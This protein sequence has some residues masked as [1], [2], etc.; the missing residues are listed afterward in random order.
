MSDERDLI[1]ARVSLVELVSQTVRLTRKGKNW[2]GLCP[3][4]DDKKPSFSVH[5]GTGTYR[6]WSCGAKGDLF[7]WIM[8][9]QRLD[10]RQA[11]ELLAKMAGVTLSRTGHEGPSKRS[12]YESAMRSANEFFQEQLR[13]HG[14]ALEYCLRRG[15]TEEVIR[16]WGLGF[17]PDVPEG[18]P[19]H[20]KKSGF[21]LGDCQEV[22]LV[23]GDPQRGYIG[24]FRGRLMFPIHDERGS[25]VAFGGRLLG[26][27]IPKYINSGDTP[28]YSKRR[29]LYGL[30]QAKNFVAKED[31]AT[32]VEGYLDVIACHRA[33]LKTA[34]A[35][36]GTS[37]S[38]EHA[39]LLAR[40][41]H[42]VTILYDGDAAGQKAADRACEVLGAAGL[43]VDVAL[44]PVGE[45]PDTLLRTA[46]PDAIHRSAKGGLSPLEFRLLR[47]RNT[48][49]PEQPKFWEESIAL[50]A[51]ATP[52]EAERAIQELAPLYPDLRDPVAAREAI[53]RQVLQKT[54]TNRAPESRPGARAPRPRFHKTE[55]TGPE[56]ALL[57]GIEQ[58]EL[59]GM[60]WP[61]L[62]RAELFPTSKAYELVTMLLDAFPDEPPKGAPREW[63]GQCEPEEV[64]FRLSDLW[65]NSEQIV[66]T[67][68]IKDAIERL[69]DRSESVA[70]R[71]AWQSESGALSEEALAEIR[72]RLIR[73]KTKKP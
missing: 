36:L 33:G 25:L 47:V 44:V 28:L 42:H 40:W 24:K 13:K 2:T 26:D 39:R 11:L 67:I 22:F 63:L 31:R 50:L 21:N 7:T 14:A 5:D 35:S 70:L 32:L 52:L 10:F 38:E 16:D 57:L 51:D 72:D 12:Q 23:E 64:R 27:G 53:K 18:L 65:V 30:D 19:N 6:C 55:M 15:L 4:H 49:S 66:D 29:V 48:T 1:K 68:V 62:R 73:L 37:L 45:D 58:P 43:V 20:L 17:A 34:I 54:R 3:F 41:C 9:T 59:R 60:I 46:G 8:E 61:I 56:L 71:Q 69:E